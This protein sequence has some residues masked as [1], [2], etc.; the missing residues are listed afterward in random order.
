MKILKNPCSAN[1]HIMKICGICKKACRWKQESNNQLCLALLVVDVNRVSLR[2]TDFVWLC[3]VLF[4]L[5]YYT[6]A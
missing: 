5:P 1:F 6:I 3:G 2:S 4:L